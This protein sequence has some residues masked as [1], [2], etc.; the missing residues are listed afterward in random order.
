MLGI[1]FHIF[2]E[3][4]LIFPLCTSVL[5]TCV[6]HVYSTHGGQKELDALELELQTVVSC[7]VGAG[8]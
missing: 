7:H 2:F 3:F 5:P 1:L 6:L 4:L 8:N